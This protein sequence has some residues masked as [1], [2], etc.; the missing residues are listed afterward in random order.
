VFSVTVPRGQPPR[1]EDAAVPTRAHGGDFSGLRILAI[2]DDPDVLE[3]LVAFLTQVGAEVVTASSV[4]E[5]REA[6]ASGRPIDAVLSDYRL[7]DGDGVSLIVELRR[8][9]GREI[10]GIIMTGETAEPVLHRVEESDLPFLH[11]PVP[12]DTLHAALQEVIARRLPA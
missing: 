11:K 12:A 5:A 9:G 7:P 1:R 6:A 8:N 3:S 4:A 10:P 2:D